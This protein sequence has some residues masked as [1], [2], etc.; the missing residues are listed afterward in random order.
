MKSKFGQYI[1]F[2]GLKFSLRGILNPSLYKPHYSI[3]TIAEINF[4]NLKK[5]GIKFIIF[6]KDNTLTKPYSKGFHPGITPN[7]EKCKSVYNYNNLMI[8]SNSAGSQ[9]DEDC[10]EALEIE[11]NLGIKVSF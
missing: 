10:E 7:I 8:L 11:K 6:D 5:N 1:N 9:D 4:K 2:E 3:N